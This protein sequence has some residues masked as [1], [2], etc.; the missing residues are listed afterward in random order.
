V[1]KSKSILEDGGI[2]P[3]SQET[4]AMS[5]PQEESLT[6]AGRVGTLDLRDDSCEDGSGLSSGDDE[7]G[8]THV[9][10]VKWMKR[11]VR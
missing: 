6:I 10:L 11:S 8:E 2:F 4:E 3:Y 1:L 7:G 9:E 5:F